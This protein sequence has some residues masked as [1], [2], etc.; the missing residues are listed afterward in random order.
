MWCD[1]I[2]FVEPISIPARTYMKF[3][4]LW[5][6][7]QLKDSQIIP[8]NSTSTENVNAIYSDAALVNWK[9][10]YR[11]LL[12][13]YAHLAL[14]HQADFDKIGVLGFVLTCMLRRII[15][16]GLESG[17]TNK[18]ELEPVKGMLKKIQREFRL[19]ESYE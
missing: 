18:K 12:R 9:M 5:I 15:L 13:V 4:L 19:N 6:Q 8:S 3:C 14:N 16:Y 1:G 10:I 17:L 11:R 7:K 2:T